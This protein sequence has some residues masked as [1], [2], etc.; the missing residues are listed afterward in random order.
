VPLLAPDSKFN[1]GCKGPGL[2]SCGPKT[3]T[4]NCFFP[5]PT[6]PKSTDPP[7]DFFNR[8]ALSNTTDHQNGPKLALATKN[9]I[10]PLHPTSTIQKRPS[11]TCPIKILF[12]E[13]TEPKIFDRKSRRNLTSTGEDLQDLNLNFKQNFTRKTSDFGIQHSSKNQT[14]T[15][16]DL[17]EDPKT[18]A[19][20]GGHNS[21]LQ[22]T[23]G[24]P[25]IGQFPGRRGSVGKNH[26]SEN[27][28]RGKC[29]GS[30]MSIQSNGSV[31]SSGN[32]V[33][34]ASNMRELMATYR[35]ETKTV[36]KAPVPKGTEMAT[37]RNVAD[38]RGFLQGLAKNPFYKKA[39][40]HFKG[41]STKLLRTLKMKRKS[42]PGLAEGSLKAQIAKNI[43]TM[44]INCPSIEH[45]ITRMSP[46]PYPAENRYMET[47]LSGPGQRPP[48]VGPSQRTDTGF[49]IIAAEFLTKQ[50]NPSK[51]SPGKGLNSAQF[52]G[53]DLA[54]PRDSANKF[55]F[56]SA[57]PNSEKKTDFRGSDQ[58]FMSSNSK[59]I[60]ATPE[61]IG[62]VTSEIKSLKGSS[63]NILEKSGN[64]M[65][66]NLGLGK[67][68]DQPDAQGN[69]LDIFKVF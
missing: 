10:D 34:V 35:P 17:L 18:L 49:G 16:F 45:L 66:F 55:N 27:L 52:L 59:N 44:K 8:L 62:D 11:L 2:N 39:N 4:A 9:L 21:F 53:S 60:S 3:D 50:I 64:Q 23:M 32:K 56:N 40:D 61:R 1:P 7:D 24:K 31:E 26:S 22:P 36:M 37:T 19:G 69:D 58:S 63:R 54:S 42:G 48:T 15:E 5:N 67:Y 65:F 68:L 43:A 33:T 20:F 29:A 51:T 47:S 6:Y 46:N 13:A 28:D 14:R 41:D 38:G 57:K 12:P 25:L 30:R